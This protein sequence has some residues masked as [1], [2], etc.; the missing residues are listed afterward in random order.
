MPFQIFRASSYSDERAVRT[1]P[2]PPDPSCSSTLSSTVVVFPLS[3]LIS[4][5]MA[6]SFGELSSACQETSRLRVHGSRR[7]WRELRRHAQSGSQRMQANRCATR[8]MGHLARAALER[9]GG[10][11]GFLGAR[12]GR[13]VGP[14]H[15]LRP[16]KAFPCGEVDGSAPLL[17]EDLRDA[18]GELRSRAGVLVL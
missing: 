18:A 7:P 10:L 1:P 11:G 13:G 15:F 4:T 3:V 8:H 14:Q 16:E 2:T 17:F 12:P 6:S 5:V 9:G